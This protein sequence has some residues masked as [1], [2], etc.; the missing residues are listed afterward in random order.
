MIMSLRQIFGIFLVILLAS[1]CTVNKDFMFKTDADFAYDAIKRDTTSGEFILAPND[2]FNFEIYTNQG[3]LI[4]EAFSANERIFLP[5]ART[6]SQFRVDPDGTVEMPVLGKVQAAGFTIQEFQDYL[7]AR[8][9]EQLVDPYCFV[10]IINRRVLVYNGNA[11]VGTV[12]GLANNNIRLIEAITIA[13]GLGARANA[14]KIK[15][16]R[17]ASGKTEVFLVDL[18]TIEGIDDANMIVENGDIIYVQSTRNL[19]RELLNEVNPVVTLATS[20]ILFITV[21]GRF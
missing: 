8:Y 2:L 20:V 19:G 4:L 21:I 15:I 10:K 3:K 12:V 14:S 18:S 7:E 6:N 9:A 11:S 16:I 17:S 1:S 13:G 5:G